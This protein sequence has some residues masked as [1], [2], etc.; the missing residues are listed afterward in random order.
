MFVRKNMDAVIHAMGSIRTARTSRIFRPEGL[1]AEEEED[2][3]VSLRRRRRATLRSRR[4]RY[5]A[6]WGESGMRDQAITEMTTEGK[7]STRKRRR[8]GEIGL[9][10][11]K[12]TMR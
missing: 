2:E 12:R 6:V 7:P 11:A 5:E 8:H 4:V 10:L 1:E 3:G 9:S